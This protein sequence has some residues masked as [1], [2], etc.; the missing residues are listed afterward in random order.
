MK[1]YLHY[2]NSVIIWGLNKT[3]ASI[4]APMVRITHSNTIKVSQEERNIFIKWCWM[5]WIA[6][7]KNKARVL[8]LTFTKLKSK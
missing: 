1:I 2:K 8:S 6:S 7:W 3:D 5:K 4:S